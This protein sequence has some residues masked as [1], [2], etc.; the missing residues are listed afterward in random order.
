MTGSPGS[1]VEDSDALGNPHKHSIRD[2]QADEKGINFPQV[3]KNP[4][5]RHP[6][7]S[8]GLMHFVL[9]SIS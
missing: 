8:R 3:E 7:E 4:Q 2:W 5:N 6:G 9:K 1:P